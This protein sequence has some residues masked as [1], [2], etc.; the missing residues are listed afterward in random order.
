MNEQTPTAGTRPELPPLVC[1]YFEQR[2]EQPD[3]GRLIFAL[4]GVTE[5]LDREQQQAGNLEQMNRIANLATA[6][7]I[8][9]E[10]LGERMAEGPHAAPRRK[11]RLRAVASE[12]GAS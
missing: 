9:A 11:P 3:V 1:L 6:A 12:G 7:W 5:A 2:A 8:L 10:Q 4:R